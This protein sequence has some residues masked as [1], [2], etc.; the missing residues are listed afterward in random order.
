M[1][2]SAISSGVTRKIPGSAALPPATSTTTS[3]VAVATRAIETA[4]STEIMGS[5]PPSRKAPG[6]AI[7]AP[8][9]H[10]PDPRKVPGT[11]DVT[12][13]VSRRKVPGAS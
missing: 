5:P 10:T 9:G 2:S 4:I 11:A 12:A 6:I 13:A 7:M 8:P 3:A 1:S